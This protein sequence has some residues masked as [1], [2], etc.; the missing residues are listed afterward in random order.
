MQVSDADLRRAYQDS[1]LFKTQRWTFEQAIAVPG[2]RNI[3]VI[4]AL[5]REQ[6]IAEANARAIQPRLI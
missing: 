5:R 2:V 1:R 3:L 6:R 4:L